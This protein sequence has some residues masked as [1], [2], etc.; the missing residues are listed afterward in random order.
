MEVGA[1]GHAA[2]HL[3]DNDR[4]LRLGILFYVLTDVILVLFLFAA[5]IWLRAYTTDGGWFP[6]QERLPDQGTTNVLTLLILLSGVS[7]VVAYQG[8]KRG[9]QTVLRIFAA[10]ALLLLIVSLIGQ[11]RFMGQQQFAT[12]DGAFPSTWITISG[13]HVYHMLVGLIVG[14]GLTVRAFQGRYTAE[15]HVGVTV[16]GYFWYWMALMPVA[17]WI[18]TAILPARL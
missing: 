3:I 8:I 17:F 1:T 6:L 16:I 18:L 15:H 9:N 7:F 4:K 14:I 13:Y 10:L 5:Y 2:E 11:I 12:I